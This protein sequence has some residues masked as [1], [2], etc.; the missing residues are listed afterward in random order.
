MLLKRLALCVVADDSV[1]DEAAEIELLSAEETHLQFVSY[2]L[3]ERW[4]SL[5]RSVRRQ[6]IE[7]MLDLVRGINRQHFLERRRAKVIP[8]IRVSVGT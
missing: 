7:A 2:F 1:V 5:D 4:E 8:P 3:L 6:T